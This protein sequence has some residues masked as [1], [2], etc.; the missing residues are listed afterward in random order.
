MKL[1]D[2]LRRAIED[3]GLTRY[4]IA[5][6]ANINESALC[7]FFHGERGLSLDAVDKLVE[8]LGLKLVA[9]DKPTAK[10]RKTRGS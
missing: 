10:K 5:Q 3:S 2:Q 1:S 9:D 7:K 6:D 4:R 8:V